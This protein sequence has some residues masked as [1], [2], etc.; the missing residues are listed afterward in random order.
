MS[1]VVA[2]EQ[3]SAD[4]LAAEIHYITPWLNYDCLEEFSPKDRQEWKRKID[5]ILV[6]P[7]IVSMDSSRDEHFCKTMNIPVDSDQSEIQAYKILC[8]LLSDMVQEN[9][10]RDGVYAELNP[11]HLINPSLDI[12]EYVQS[13]NATYRGHV[14]Q[15]SSQIDAVGPTCKISVCIPVAAHEE[16]EYVYD[17]LSCFCDQTLPPDK[18]E[19][20]ILANSPHDLTAETV[21]TMQEIT[22]FKTEFPEINIQVMQ[23][24]LLGS[25]LQ[26]IGFIRALLHDAVVL[27]HGERQGNQDHIMVRCD[28]DT[29]AVGPKYLENFLKRFE[30]KS[31]TD[32][33]AGWLCHSPEAAL[34]DPLIF[35]SQRLFDIV[36]SGR[37]IYFSIPSH[38]GPNHAIK[39]SVYAKLGGYS[40]RSICGEDLKLFKQH[41]KWRKS[42][43]DFVALGH[44]GWHSR[45]YTSSR[46][47]N[48]SCDSG[49]TYASQ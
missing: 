19:V 15:I 43:R 26:T 25:S 44:G 14:E 38:G 37:R 23:V 12:A 30:Q 13:W 16:Q 42:S 24:G 49:G 3:T 46:R 45:L 48:Y 22:R 28:A 33:F 21:A 11:D 5:R 6:D 20:V 27:R 31:G 2:T 17:A 35:I 36:Y 34:K 47:G 40:E 8:R 4:G 32:S 10:R 18:F 9:I 7:D 29:R 1:S 41:I 39:A